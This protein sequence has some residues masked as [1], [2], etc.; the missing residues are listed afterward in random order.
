MK[1]TAIVENTRGKRGVNAKHGLS[2]LLEGEKFGTMLFDV[3]PDVRLLFSNAEK[4]GIDLLQTETV[5]LSHGHIDHG[6]ALHD[7]LNRNKQAIV[8]LKREALSE[9]ITKTAGISIPVSVRLY[10]KDVPR[11]IFTQKV[12]KISPDIFLFSEVEP[13]KDRKANRALYQR[14]NNGCVQDAF[15][16][17]QNL[18]ICEQGKV[19]LIAGCAHCGIERIIKTAQELVGREVD[20]VVSGFHLYNPVTR[21]GEK[22]ETIERFGQQLSDFSCRYVTFHCTG[23]RA[24]RL[25][26][27]QLGDRITYLRAGQSVII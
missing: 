14:T 13:T 1:I 8:F 17:E 26:K 25:L 4:L 11:L 16:H 20:V 19:I 12:H 7:F 22:R 9:Y 18:V 10:E 6:G 23:K 3:G 5:I 27:Q 24:Y 2:L 21:R 15:L